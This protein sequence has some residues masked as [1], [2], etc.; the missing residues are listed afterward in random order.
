MVAKGLSV[1]VGAITGKLAFTKETADSF[2]AQGYSVVFCTNRPWESIGIRESDG[3]LLLNGTMHSLGSR[4]AR[5]LGKCG[6]ALV[7][8]CSPSQ[9]SIHRDANELYLSNGGI[10]VAGDELT[11]D[12]FT[13][14]IYAG[15][16]D[17][18]SGCTDPDY[19][20]IMEWANMYKQLNVLAQTGSYKDAQKAAEHGADGIGLCCTDY[21]ISSKECK[22]W[23]SAALISQDLSHIMEFLNKAQ[24]FHEE[25]VLKVIALMP[26]KQVSFRLLNSPLNFLP[27]LPHSIINN[28]SDAPD[29]STTYAARNQHCPSSNIAFSTSQSYDEFQDLSH[30]LSMDLQS[31]YTSVRD[32]RETS[33]LGFCGSRWCVVYPEVVAMQT[34]AIIGAA[35][36]AT[37]SGHTLGKIEI[38]FPLV[39][40]DNEIE[41][42]APILKDAAEMVMHERGMKLEYHIGVSL[43]GPRCCIKADSI[44]KECAID[45]V[46][47]NTNRLTQLIYGFSE[48]DTGRFLNTYMNKHILATNPFKSIDRRGVGAMMELGINKIRDASSVHNKKPKLKIGI[49]GEQGADPYSVAYYNGLKVN[50]ISVPPTKISVAKI[51]AAQAYIKENPTH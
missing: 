10:L 50:N 16:M 46:T 7:G 17:M 31:V 20:R 19:H 1:S 35:I 45:F 22:L 32:M 34:R 26:Q 18:A 11:L 21:M 49:C 37:K 47:F 12:G 48:V 3:L 8:E 38:L 51:S 30:L 40:S 42:I 6:V 41:C 27:I 9:F 28:G 36:T 5:S 2:A 13:G 44:V 14:N 25:E 39:V 43:E 4:M 24:P 33:F 15:T 23:A 29:M